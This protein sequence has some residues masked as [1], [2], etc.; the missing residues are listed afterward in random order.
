MSRLPRPTIRLRLT[1]LYGGLF[2]LSG[3]ALLA[4]NFV[5]VARATEPPDAVCVRLADPAQP[6]HIDLPGPLLAPLPDDVAAGQPCPDGATA[7]AEARRRALELNRSDGPYGVVINGR[8]PVDFLRE[9]REENLRRTLIQSTLALAGMALGS[10]GLGWYLAGRTLRPLHDITAAARRISIDDLHQR[11]ALEGPADEL[12]ELADTFDAMLARL[13]AALASQRRFVADASHELRT[14]LAVM[15]T[16]LEVTL[17][18]EHADVGELRR[19]AA[20]VRDALARSEQL[21]GSLLVLARSERDVALDDEVDL[22]EVAAGVAAAAGGEAEAAS[23]ALETELWP[24]PVRGDRALLERLVAN[25]VENG[26]RH[27]RPGGIVQIHTSLRD[28]AATLSVSNDGRPVNPADGDRMFEPFVRLGEQRPGGGRGLGLGLAIVRAV[29]TAH[30][31]SLKATPRPAGGLEV[32]VS[33]PPVESRV[34]AVPVP[35]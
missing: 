12:Q 16:E 13:E 8:S 14:P 26:V 34:G 7:V 2:L 32:T 9:Q 25:L 17:A 23:M 28:G 15:R 4:I 29:A 5:L 6:G 11:I 24:A 3:A 22:G 33:F 30:G 31:A 21:V 19:M 1:L 27:G 20:T 10:I 18:D 35:V